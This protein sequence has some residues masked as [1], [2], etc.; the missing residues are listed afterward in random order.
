MTRTPAYYLK[1]HLIRRF[2]QFDLFAWTVYDKDYRICYHT[3]AT[4][5]QIQ[6][7]CKGCTQVSAIAVYNNTQ[8]TMGYKNLPDNILQAFKENIAERD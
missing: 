4:A 5:K 2:A 1:R 7:E 3:D 8:G 6:K